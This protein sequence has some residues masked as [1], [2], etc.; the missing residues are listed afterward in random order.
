MAE[1]VANEK[2]STV[3]NNVT[4]IG[5][6]E[7]GLNEMVKQ[8]ETRIDF[9]LKSQEPIKQMED[10]S[11][12]KKDLADL[13]IKID[14]LAKVIGANYESNLESFRITKTQIDDKIKVLSE[15]ISGIIERV[16]EYENEITKMG[17]IIITLDKKI[18]NRIGWG[19]GII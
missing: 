19:S 13:K 9:A 17:G 4:R 14:E 11:G 1:K 16:L 18:S 7:H 10:V 12:I 6:I 15:R 2:L 5:E 8:A 3:I